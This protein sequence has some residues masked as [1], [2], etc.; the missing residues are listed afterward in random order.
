MPTSFVLYECFRQYS[1]INSFL[2]ICLSGASEMK[3]IMQVDD[4][5]KSELISIPRAWDKEKS[6]SPTGIEPMTLHL[7]HCSINKFC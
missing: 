3:N 6:D 4:Y 7:Y 5:L 2:A 1:L